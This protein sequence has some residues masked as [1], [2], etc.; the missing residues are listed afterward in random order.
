MSQITWFKVDDQLA[1]HHKVVKVG[2]A[3]MGLWVRCGAW[4]SGAETDGMVPDGIVNALGGTTAQANRLVKEGL[5][6]RE[7]EGYR[8]HDWH[9]FQPSALDLRLA[10]EKE[11]ESGT[12]GNHTKWH[13]RRG[14]NNPEC[15]LCLDES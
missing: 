2:N 12:K 13:V 11:S 9:I 8:F 4:S 7:P 14:I 1:L 5:W 6:H 15:P 3:C 10:R